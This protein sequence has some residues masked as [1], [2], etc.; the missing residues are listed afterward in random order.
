VSQTLEQTNI[1]LVEKFSDWEYTGSGI[2]QLMPA[3]QAAPKLLS[4]DL[5]P[6]GWWGTIISGD[7]S[8]DP[9]PW[10]YVGVNSQIHVAGSDDPAS[11]GIMW[12]WVR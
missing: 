2:E 1:E 9:A 5:G 8:Y 7:G 11:P 6:G 10:I 4:T 12:Y 3:V